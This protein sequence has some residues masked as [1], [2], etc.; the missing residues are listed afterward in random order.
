VQPLETLECTCGERGFIGLNMDV[1]AVRSNYQI[2]TRTI[3]VLKN[4][5]SLT[6]SLRQGTKN[7]GALITPKMVKVT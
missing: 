1:L 5:Y 3:P 6:H 2:E 4:P 7:T